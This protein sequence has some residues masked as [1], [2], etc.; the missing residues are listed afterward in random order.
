MKKF[1]PIFVTGV[2]RSGATF[3]ARILQ[4]CGGRIG[5]CDSMF[6]NV[7]I[8]DVADSILLAGTLLPVVATEK[9]SL[10]TYKTA[11]ALSIGILEKQRL[12]GEN[13]VLKNS[14]FS[15][16]WRY[17]HKMFPD[18]RWVII[19]RKPPYIVNSCVKTAHMRTM[20]STANLKAINANTEKEGW[21][22]LVHQY[23]AQW[24]AMYECRELS[25]FEVYPDRMEN[26]DY[27]KI[28]ILVKELGLQWTD[29]VVEVMNPY[30]T[31]K[32]ER[33]CYGM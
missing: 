10:S 16:S 31:D 20:K 21:M 32:K 24:R 11:K 1:S 26:K 8:R 28:K 23:E 3:I 29:N 4:M 33:E 5:L 17:W 9:V 27:S 19:R 13:T 30:F 18:A 2:P 12:I 14:G 6:E 15:L 25:I 22:W 7:L